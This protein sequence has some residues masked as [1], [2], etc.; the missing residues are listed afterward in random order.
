MSDRLK[1]RIAV[2][3]G[4]SRGCG[5]GIAVALGEQAATVYVTGRSVRG[6][7]PPIDGAHP[8]FSDIT[9][10]FAGQNAFPETPVALHNLNLIEN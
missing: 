5:R 2:V 9:L 6:G 4:A 10:L 3:A 7:P 1:G 8:S